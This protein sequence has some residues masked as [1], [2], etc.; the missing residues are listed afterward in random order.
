[1]K[2]IK[3]ISLISIIFPFNQIALLHR[4]ADKCRGCEGDFFQQEPCLLH[5]N[6][7]WHH[8]CL[9]CDLCNK[10][11]KANTPYLCPTDTEAK[12][13]DVKP[14]IGGTQS[15][16][17]KRNFSF[18]PEYWKGVHQI[19]CM[20]CVPTCT[21]CINPVIHNHV[22]ALGRHWHHDCFRCSSCGEVSLL[23][24]NAY[25]EYNLLRGN[26]TLTNS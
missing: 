18:S 4:S 12:L 17:R 20:K 10:E 5:D 8:G 3:C 26:N 19:I 1:M 24:K 7:L 21:G 13:A 22:M 25:I 16:G 14:V 2:S 9:R 6:R 15:L 11:I 23:V